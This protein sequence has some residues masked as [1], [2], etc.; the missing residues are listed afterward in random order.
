MD[1]PKLAWLKKHGITVKCH[2]WKGT[3]YEGSDEGR[4]Q[5]FSRDSYAIE[6]DYFDDGFFW[7]NQSDLCETEDEALQNIATH[8]G[9]KL[10]NEEASA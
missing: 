8:L 6:S 1:S 9:L 7:C 3:D 2:D 5:A 10:W 4:W